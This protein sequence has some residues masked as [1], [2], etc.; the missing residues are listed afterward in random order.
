MG[1]A[2]I[3]LLLAALAADAPL[4]DDPLSLFVQDAS[5]WLLAGQAL[6]RDYRLG[7]LAME[8]GDR[9]RAI[10]YLRR[11]GLLSGPPWPVVDLLRPVASDTETEE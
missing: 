10:A 7:L 6:P 5:G 4:A 2:A 9:I 11:V 8:P 1:G 3:S